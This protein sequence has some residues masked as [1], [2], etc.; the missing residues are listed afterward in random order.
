M[1]FWVRNNNNNNAPHLGAAQGKVPKWG[2]P[3]NKL[4]RWT[5]RS[6]STLLHQVPNTNNTLVLYTCGNWL[7]MRYQI[8]CVRRKP[9]YNPKLLM[10]FPFNYLYKVNQMKHNLFQSQKITLNFWVRKKII[11]I[12]MQSTK[13]MSAKKKNNNKSALQRA[14]SQPP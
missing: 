13:F 1:N 6:L 11:I 8:S 9:K 5:S 4:I 14:A 3:Y 2:D 12:T 10:D 7:W